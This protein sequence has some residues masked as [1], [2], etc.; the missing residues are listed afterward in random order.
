MRTE[1]CGTTPLTAP[2]PNARATGDDNP[3]W[4]AEGTTE[5]AETPPQIE[6]HGFIMPSGKH[7]G[8]RLT[9][10]PVSYLKW[11]VREN[12]TLGVHAQAELDRRGT[13]TPDIEISGHAIDSASLRIRKLWHESRGEQEGLHA[14]LC[15]MATA[16]LADGRLVEQGLSGDKIAYGGALWC[17][18]R[19]GAWPLLKTVMRDERGHRE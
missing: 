3:P 5:R 12:H 14:W 1:N 9:R 2:F 7:Q 4:D 18:T 11:M 19:S 8:E 6:T 10:V 17:F 13:V 15:R 16:A